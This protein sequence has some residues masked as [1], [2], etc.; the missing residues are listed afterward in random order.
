MTKAISHF[1]EEF[2]RAI[3][4]DHFQSEISFFFFQEK[5]AS[6]ILPVETYRGIVFRCN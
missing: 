4:G 6:W 2:K 5:I 3:I 1:I